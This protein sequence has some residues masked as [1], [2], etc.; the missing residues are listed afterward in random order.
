MIWLMKVLIALGMIPGI[1]EK[2]IPAR[3]KNGITK[4]S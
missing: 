1:V 4:R 3:E 2:V